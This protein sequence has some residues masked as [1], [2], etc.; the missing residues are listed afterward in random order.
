MFDRNE[1]YGIVKSFCLKGDFS[2]GKMS[3]IFIPF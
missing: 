3:G 1:M 2:T